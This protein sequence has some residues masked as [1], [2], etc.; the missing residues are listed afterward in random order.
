MLYYNI[1]LELNFRD[2]RC[3]SYDIIKLLSKQHVIVEYSY[4]F[5]TVQKI[6][7]TDQEMQEL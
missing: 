6:T 1:K 3:V 4:L 7:R 5:R 2:L